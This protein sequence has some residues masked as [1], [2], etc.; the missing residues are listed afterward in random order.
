MK[1]PDVME[2]PY[3]VKDIVLDK[4]SMSLIDLVNQRQIRES[5]VN[6]ILSKL[7]QGCHFDS[8]FVVNVNNGTKRIRVLDGGHRTEALKKFFEKKPDAK[9]R[10]SMAVYNDLTETEERQ[11]FTKWNLGVKQSVDDF[12]KSYKVEIPE[13]E[14]MIEELPVSIYGSKNKLKLR[15]VVDAYLSSKTNPYSGGCGYTRLQWLSVLKN[16]DYDNIQSMKDTVKIM[17]TIF[18]PKDIDDFTRLTAFKFSNFKSVY[19][20]IDV[21]KV[22]LG[23]NYVIKR[24]SK[25]LFNHPIMEQY[26]AGHRQG[27]VESFH[28]YKKLLNDGVEH[29]FK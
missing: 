16:I 7:K 9:V 5:Q 23:K 22:L 1:K 6:S 21:N 18:N 25:I 4:A 20:L 8:M 3:N 27:T 11:V 19:R 13:Y 14:T 2:Y 15:F 17:N 12:I 24:M 26:R 29:K 28:V 10:V